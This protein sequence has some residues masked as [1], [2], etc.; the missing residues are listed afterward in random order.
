MKRTIQIMMLLAPVFLVA[1]TSNVVLPQ[2][3][4]PD[5]IDVSAYPPAQQTAYKLFA[6]KCSKCHT[7]ARP[8]NTM[9]KRDEWERYVKR[10]MHKPN[11][12]ISDNQGKQ[13][14]D[15]MV[16]DQTERK[17]KNPKAFFPALSDEEI[18]KLK[19]Q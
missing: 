7:I 2:D 4:G 14:F 12:G 18:E 1:Q 19:K 6:S 10:M 15:F 8:L 13:I 9:M 3:K 11:S 16:Y 17:D 5:K